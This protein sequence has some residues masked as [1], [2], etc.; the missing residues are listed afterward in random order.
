MGGR[1]KKEGE[2]VEK[3]R[4]LGEAGRGRGDKNRHITEVVLTNRL[5]QQ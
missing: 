4:E 3:G 2:K 5:S 1:G